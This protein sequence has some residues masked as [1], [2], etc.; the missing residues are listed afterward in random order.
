MLNK[1]PDIVFI[2]PSDGA[3]KALIGGIPSIVSEQ[4]DKVSVSNSSG[5]C[6]RVAAISASLI[7]VFI[8]KN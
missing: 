4:A 5:R 8:A 1:E 6:F 2:S 3:I 7:I